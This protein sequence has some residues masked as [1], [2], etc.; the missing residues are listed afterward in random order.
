MERKT[1]LQTTNYSSAIQTR[2]L[3]LSTPTLRTLPTVLSL[4]KQILKAHTTTLVKKP[5][6][7]V[8]AV[9]DF[10]L[11]TL[12]PWYITGFS[13]GEACFH[14][15]LKK[16]SDLKTGWH[17]QASYQIAL[18]SKDILELICAHFGVGSVTQKGKDEHQYRVFS[19][20]DLKVI[21]SHFDKYPLISQKRADFELFKE[22]VEL[23]NGLTPLEHT[24][25][26]GL[27]RIVNLRA[28]MNKGLSD[29]LIAA[30]P[31]TTPVGRPLVEDQEIKDPNWLAGFVVGEGCFMVGVKKSSTHK[32]GCQV[33]LSFRIAQ[34]SRDERL[35]KSLTQ[36]L[37]CGQ[38]YPLSPLPPTMWGEGD[39]RG[40]V[41]KYI[42]IF[43]TALPYPS[44]YPPLKGRAA[45]KEAGDFS[46]EKYPDTVKIIAFFEKYPLVGNKLQDFSDFKKAADILKVKG[47]LTAEG[48]EQIRLIQA[49]INRNR[50]LM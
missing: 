2:V 12:N 18:H 4:N 26:E 40:S 8:S 32:L 45:N 39:I 30:F 33:Q 25:P 3:L 37:G 31:N 50:K 41:K 20:A 38:Y 43:F 24:N 6:L 21:I 35:M 11:T 13:D 9:A 42:Y 44:Q 48:L 34:H 17:V 7:A 22:I 5:N 46:V 29:V 47:H 14:V 15:S 10:S 49:G 19:F 23:V 1:S 36:Y 28:S 16:R 27:Q